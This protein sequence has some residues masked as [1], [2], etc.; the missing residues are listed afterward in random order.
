MRNVK[1][2]VTLVGVGFGVGGV[3]REARAYDLSKLATQVSSAKVGA[4]SISP[5]LTLYAPTSAYKLDADQDGLVDAVDPC[6]MVSEGTGT[7]SLQAGAR[8]YVDADNLYAAP[9]FFPPGFK[10]SDKGAPPAWNKCEPVVSYRIREGEHDGVVILGTRTA[11]TNASYVQLMNNVKAGKRSW[12]ENLEAD[13]L[14]SIDYKTGN[15]LFVDNST[16]ATFYARSKAKNSLNFP[17]EGLGLLLA[18]SDVPA[19]EGYPAQYSV[20]GNSAGDFKRLPFSRGV[21]YGKNLTPLSLGTSTIYLD[22]TIPGGFS[23][24]KNLDNTQFSPFLGSAPTSCTV[25]TATNPLGPPSNDWKFVPT[26]VDQALLKDALERAKATGSTKLTVE[27]YPSVREMNNDILVVEPK[28]YLLYPQ[29]ILYRGPGGTYVVPGEVRRQYQNFMHGNNGK[30]K[31]MPPQNAAEYGISADKKSLFVSQDFKALLSQANRWQQVETISEIGAKRKVL[32][33][34]SNRQGG[35]IPV[36][37]TTNAAPVDCWAHGPQ[38]ADLMN[39]YAAKAAVGTEVATDWCPSALHDWSAKQPV[40][41]SYAS[42]AQSCKAF[43]DTSDKLRNNKITEIAKSLGISNTACGAYEALLEGPIELGTTAFADT[44]CCGASIFTLGQACD[45][46][47]KSTKEEFEEAANETLAC[48]IPEVLKRLSTQL[49]LSEQWV[50]ISTPDHRYVPFVGY[51]RWPGKSPSMETLM[52]KY[53]SMAN[54]AHQGTDWNWKAFEPKAVDPGYRVM[55]RHPDA[56]ANEP[57]YAIEHELEFQVPMGKWTENGHLL[58]D[59]NLHGKTPYHW[60]SSGELEQ[61]GALTPDMFCDLFGIDRNNY[62]KPNNPSIPSCGGH[63]EWVPHFGRGIFFPLLDENPKLMEGNPKLP[64]SVPNKFETSRMGFLGHPIVDCG[65]E[66]Y[67]LELHPPHLITTDGRTSVSLSPKLRIGREMITFGWVN[68]SLPGHLEFD[69]WP[70]LARPSPTAKLV[71]LGIDTELAQPA[72]GQTSSPEFGFVIDASGPQN[73][74]SKPTLT[75]S[76]LPAALP[77]H[78]HCVYDDP[79]GG[80][81]APSK[82]DEHYGNER[83]QPFFATSRFEARFFVG[84]EE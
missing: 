75:C 29:G 67:H 40:N 70:D 30:T 21:L 3:V 46:K 10:D 44:V 37:W 36:R 63:S 15:Y 42:A 27:G 26:K 72:S 69:L 74:G 1:L 38:D 34:S 41:N 56:P 19:H 52:T 68:I 31:V 51:Q 78:V 81:R 77:N 76:S 8:C 84:W 32:V 80:P 43:K 12:P 24:G 9:A 6:P 14:F 35:G 62:S 83:M 58:T 17:Q 64:I 54:H 11:T 25:K 13:C 60:V 57:K 55:G 53:D 23:V 39:P 79:S 50:D 48:L 2:L 73:Q 33:A 18:S 7:A 45:C 20:W 28:A 16:L 4:G 47:Y 61:L 71:A 49:P 22:C 66:D 59:Y 5:N 82:T 65:H